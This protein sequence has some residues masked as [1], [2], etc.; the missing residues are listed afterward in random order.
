MGSIVMF[1]MF[2]FK[3]IIGDKH[4]SLSFLKLHTIDSTWLDKTV[5]NLSLSHNILLNNGNFSRFIKFVK[6]LGRIINVSLITR[7][8]Y[9][10]SYNTELYLIR[11]VNP[12]EPIRRLDTGV[13]G[14]HLDFHPLL[15]YRGKG[16][17]ATE[18]IWKCDDF[19]IHPLTET[20]SHNLSGTTH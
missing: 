1:I 13:E 2:Y 9:D 4:P 18:S 20:A 14:C 19:R 8:K 16:W 3:I 11:G 15:L 5:I 7:V 17:T 6:G 10:Y 12:F